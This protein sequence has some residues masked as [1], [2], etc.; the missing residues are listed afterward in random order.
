MK[1][2]PKTK[3]ACTQV[4]LLYKKMDIYSD[5]GWILEDFEKTEIDKLQEK[6]TTGID[7]EALFNLY[8]EPHTS[9]TT[10]YRRYK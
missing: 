9:K 7:N 3:G 8:I 10:T 2:Y 6:W 1:F 5:V 4:Y